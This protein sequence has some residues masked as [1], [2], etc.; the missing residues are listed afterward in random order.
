MAALE[1]LVLG[2]K[3]TSESETAPGPSPPESASFTT[4]SRDA[5]PPDPRHTP[6]TSHSLIHAKLDLLQQRSRDARNRAETRDEAP[7]P[8]TTRNEVQ[9]EPEAQD[10]QRAEDGQST[11]AERTVLPDGLEKLDSRLAALYTAS[12]RTPAGRAFFDRADSAITSALRVAPEPGYFTVDL[13]GNPSSF[14]VGSEKLNAHD[15]GRLVLADAHWDHQPVRLLSC[16][17]GQ[18]DRP[19]AQ[20]LANE[21]GVDVLA[22]T[23][24]V[25]VRQTTGETVVSSSVLDDEGLPVPKIPYDG[26]WKIFRPAE[27]T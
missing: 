12:Q 5:G 25:W 21:L 24:V 11:A 15:L 18:G 8:A 1:R 7:I 6:G 20:E 26:L 10:G 3:E 19:V 2:G 23:E 27:E 16:R 9:D 4:E 14:L 22:P 17:T 13:H